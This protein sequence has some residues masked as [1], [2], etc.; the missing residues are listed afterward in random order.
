MGSPIRSLPRLEDDVDDCR[1]FPL[2][3]E[4]PFRGAGA[5]RRTTST[6]GTAESGI[7]SAKNVPPSDLPL[8][9]LTVSAVRDRSSE[10]ALLCS[11]KLDDDAVLNEDR[12]L[13]ELE[14]A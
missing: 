9:D 11:L 3:I 4:R 8:P 6:M 7:T 1:T 5:L 13:P 14:S 10:A 12:Q 2:L